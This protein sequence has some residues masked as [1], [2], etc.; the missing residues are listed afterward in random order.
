MRTTHA[1]SLRV[2]CEQHTWSVVRPVLELTLGYFVDKRP[3]QKHSRLSKSLQIQ[4]LE[5]FKLPYRG[6][7]NAPANII[8]YTNLPPKA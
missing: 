3:L 5:A 6:L 4:S 2:K 1:H 7:L 8:Y